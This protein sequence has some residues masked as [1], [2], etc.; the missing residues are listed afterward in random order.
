[1]NGGI[2][3]P[4][5]KSCQTAASTGHGID[6]WKLKIKEKEEYTTY[7][8]TCKDI[9]YAI[10]M[11]NVWEMYLNGMLFIVVLNLYEYIMK[12]INKLYIVSYSLELYDNCI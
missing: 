6:N 5:R 2:L 9:L 8:N 10:Y 7:K 1:M 12:V 11:Q 3:T 4:Q